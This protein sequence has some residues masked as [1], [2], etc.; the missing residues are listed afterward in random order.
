VR[1]D[2]AV[3]VNA[4]PSLSSDTP[5]DFHLKF[6]MV[7]AALSLADVD[8]QF[9]GNTPASYNGFDLICDNG[10]FVQVSGRDKHVM[11]SRK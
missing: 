1:F 10:S 5:A 6:A 11:F 2:A 7:D 3:Q 9:G 4:S 8:N